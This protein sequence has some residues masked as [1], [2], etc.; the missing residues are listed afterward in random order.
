VGQEDAAS[1]RKA[2]LFFAL[3]PDEKLRCQLQEQPAPRGRLVPPQNWHVTLLFLGAVEPRAQRAM[4]AAADHVRAASFELTLDLRGH[5]RRAGVTWLSASRVPGALESLHAQLQGAAQAQG[6]PLEQRPFVPHLTL[7]RKA[8][9]EAR[10][11]IE[12]IDWAVEE[13]CL[14]ESATLPTGAQYRVL[15]RWSLREPDASE[16]PVHA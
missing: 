4:A 10:Q 13:F 9:A 15:R 7:A 3:W 1:E 2:R 8:A 11:V 12:P 16:I 5:W 6:I 14:V